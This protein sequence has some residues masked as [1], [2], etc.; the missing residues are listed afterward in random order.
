MFC[1]TPPADAKIHLTDVPVAPTAELI[2]LTVNGKEYQTVVEPHD[3]LSKV[4]RN[5]LDLTGT[6]LGCEQAANIL[7]S[8]LPQNKDSP[9]RCLA[10]A[11]RC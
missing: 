6:K 4:L 11:S 3:T 9:S 2:K 7:H 1:A 8:F 5:K 10:Q